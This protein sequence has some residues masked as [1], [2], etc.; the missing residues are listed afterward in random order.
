MKIY[1]LCITIFAL[2]CFTL[3]M[4]S[5]GYFVERR[6]VRLI[7]FLPND[8]PFRAEV[9][10]R[11]KDEILDIQEFYASQMQ[12]HGYGRKTFPLETDLWSRPIVHRVNGNYPEKYYL[13]DAILVWEEIRERFET[14]DTINFIV[15]DNSTDKINPGGATGE[16]AL[17]GPYALVTSNF[18]W[19]TAAHELGH[20]F[21]LH[22][23]F[24]DDSYL[25][26]YGNTR[27]RL[28]ACAAKFLAV[29][30][31]FNPQIRKRETAFSTIKHLSLQE[32]PADAKSVKIQLEV[33]D[34]DGL[35]Q[36]FLMVKTKDSLGNDGYQVIACQDLN[37]E[38]EAIVTFY[39][40]G[41]IPSKGNTSLSDPLLH[42]ISVHAIDTFSNRVDSSL[43]ETS[44]ISEALTLL[45][46]H[47]RI[48]SGNKQR[49]VI[50]TALTNA[51]VVEIEDQI[52]RGL[53]GWPV[54]FAVTTGDGT[55]SVENTETNAKGRAQ[56]TL[57][58]GSMQG[59]NTV[60]VIIPELE[61]LIFTAFGVKAPRP[62]LIDGSYQTWQLPV[63][64]VR[65]FGKGEPRAV[66]F[67]PD[68]NTL[69]VG[70]SIG[71]WLYDVTTSR[72][73]AL[74][75]GHRDTVRSVIFSSDG[76][77]LVSIGGLLD[78]TIK[79][80]T[81]PAGE[82]LA[83]F[84]NTELIEAV[85]LSPD[86]TLIA[87]G[88]GNRGPGSITLWDIATKRNIATFQ[89]DMHGVLSLAFSPDGTTL[90]SGS[91]DGKVKIWNVRTGQHTELAGHVG[92][93][94]SMVY[95]PDATK[96]ASA[97]GHDDNTIK[98]WDAATGG[99]I[100]T[101]HTNALVSIALSPDGT[102]IA[103]AE[104]Y[105][106]S[107]R[108][109]LW[110][111]ATGRQVATLSG[112][113]R[114]VW[115]VAFSPDGTQIV[116]GS[117]DN[118]I[119][120]WSLSTHTATATLDHPN[121]YSVA[122]S[123]DK[124]TFASTSRNQEIKLWNVGTG[125]NSKTLVGH[126][127][128]VWSL[129]FSP[130]G[131]ALASTARDGEIRLWNVGTGQNTDTL[132]GHGNEVRTLTFSPDGAMLAS[133]SEGVKVKLWNVK[134]E[135]NTTL[136]HKDIV[137]S[138]A[139]S[140]DGMTLA[141]GTEGGK[142]ELWNIGTGQN[143]DT[144][145]GQKSRIRS[146]AF[147]PD[148]MTLASGTEG[149][150]VELWN[151]GTGQN[152]DISVNS[153]AVNALAFSPDG[154]ILAT[155]SKDLKLWDVETRENIDIF[156]GH[157]DPV[158]YILFSPDQTTLVSGSYDG[159]VLLWDMSPH[160]TP[161]TPPHS[162]TMD[163]TDV[164]SDGIVNIQDLVLVA[165]NFGKTGKNVA[166]INGDRVVNIVDLTLVAGA[167]GDGLAAPPAWDHDLEPT[168]T[169][170]DIQQ[171][172]REARRVNLP[173][174]VFQRGILMLEHLLTSLT[175]KEMALLPNYPNPFNPET[176]IPYQLA[177]PADV[178]LT[179]YTSNGT[180]VRTLMLGYQPVGIYQG[181]GRA[182][183]W[184]GKNE[185]GEP[186]ASGLYFYTLTAGNF[187]ATRKMLIQK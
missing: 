68:G 53:V 130:D 81:L 170:A 153:T 64:A 127:N 57:T 21:G 142:V 23:D 131:M 31:T 11:L 40:D 77:K 6:T 32:Y 128:I 28:S 74:L 175:P 41:V 168:L 95:F 27:N 176:W 80:W 149:G 9:V 67:S 83:T 30:P 110:S 49:G 140:P 92:P 3:S 13:N 54:M 37:G 90:A 25:M 137:L 115:S 8:R 125:Q 172:L 136:I 86:G 85:A 84:T 143:I 63:G 10:Q 161:T 76:T 55:L 123:P 24:R 156:D 65:R 50:N 160:L 135:Q 147:S 134:T 111:V 100:R 69:A 157:T 105:Y 18:R 19:S 120:F 51:F 186:V 158:S 78:K 165:S 154:T 75:T 138:L 62:L 56:T 15:I 45:P 29:S 152:G 4:P 133:V 34:P 102:H 121:F 180:V 177:K 132:V 94:V 91:Y 2:I 148:G 44:L 151:V 60:E 178:T 43:K 52:R 104:G 162:F 14:V 122:F 61:P 109:K 58:L 164:N 114:G 70:S 106:N 171:W 116:S 79:L 16:A 97:G 20:A 141:S 124:T 101:I 103:S 96:I 88:S 182:A 89:G 166:D 48:I 82:N 87:A 113:T 174:A 7:Y 159:T 181:K 26:S 185:V 129:A 184:D 107:G 155:G 167:I 71:T 139:F 117:R 59:V 46:I 183:Y 150:K 118:T 38:T 22:H 126:R 146:L 42:P 187:T 36:V 108:I 47:R 112:H 73:L 17:S 173:A 163:A 169:R 39:Y 145:V 66:T 33:S 72:E 179:I 12:D 35:Y 119:K 99:H 98:L 1:L 5:W 93:I 144:L